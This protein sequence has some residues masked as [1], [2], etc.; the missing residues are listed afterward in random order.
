MKIKKMSFENI[1]NELT[2]EEMRSIMAGSGSSTGT[3][4]PGFPGNPNPIELPPLIVGGNPNP[5]PFY[6]TIP[7]TNPTNPSIP[8]GGGS[9]GSYI[10]G[11]YGGTGSLS[12]S[13]LYY[14]GNQAADSARNLFTN[15]DR[16]SNSFQHF[17]PSAM[18]HKLTE[19]EHSFLTDGM[20]KVLGAFG[21]AVDSHN[22]STSI[23]SL[24]SR[25]VGTVLAK[26]NLAT[27]M[28]SIALGG[29]VA[30]NNIID[31]GGN[32]G[33]WIAVGL[34]IAGAIVLTNPGTIAATATASAVLSTMSFVNDA[35]SVAGGYN[36][37]N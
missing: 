6:P 16:Q 4:G 27:G 29:I 10:G 33:D 17:S 24:V 30:A 31:N 5:N 25:D 36:S 2:Q 37:Y 9:G 1:K 12:P 13:E 34:V 22:L 35:I 21:F 32:A 15:Y 19:D 26:A 18:S 23:V 11:G 14:Y 3:A 8:G 28:A 20:T 7:G